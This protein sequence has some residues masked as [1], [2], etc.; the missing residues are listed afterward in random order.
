MMLGARGGMGTGNG[1]ST[2]TCLLDG[3][4]DAYTGR[5]MGSF[6]QE[7]ADERGIT[8]EQMDAF[9]IESLNRAKKAIESG[10][11]RRKSPR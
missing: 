11:L 9:A 8:R 5:A 2:I 1:T 6:A 3:L 7:T 10:S 4:E